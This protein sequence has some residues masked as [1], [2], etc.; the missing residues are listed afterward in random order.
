V[1]VEELNRDFI[2]ISRVIV[3][4]KYIGI[5]LGVEL[6]KETLEKTGYRY[7]EAIAVMARY[8]PFFKKSRY[9]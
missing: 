1:D 2:T 8:N 5:G 7:V 6:V 3:H 9:G 4:P